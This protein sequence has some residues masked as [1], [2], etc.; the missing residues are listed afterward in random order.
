[1][2]KP[3][4][5]KPQVSQQVR[6]PQPMRAFTFGEPEQVL[7]GNIGEYLGVFLSDDGEIYKPP[8]SRAGLAK[9]LRATGVPAAFHEE[10]H[11]LHCPMYREDQ[12]GGIWLQAAGAVRNPY[13]G[14]SMIGC[15]DKR[16]SL[17]VAGS[18][19]PGDSER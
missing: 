6:Q 4:H 15:F 17:P 13:F 2:P 14:S 11:Q 3:R 7:S 16:E 12:G 18:S 8:V 10:I 9:L 1:M 5:K 19:Q